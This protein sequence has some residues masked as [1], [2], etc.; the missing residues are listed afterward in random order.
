VLGRRRRGESDEGME[1]LENGWA[2]VYVLE[3]GVEAYMSA[4]YL[5]RDTQ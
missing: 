1:L 2:K 3:S 4:D 5:A